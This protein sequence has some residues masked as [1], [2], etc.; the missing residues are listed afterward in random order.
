MKEADAARGSE[1]PLAA[2]RP[3]AGRML[4]NLG[5]FVSGQD[6]TVVNSGVT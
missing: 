1:A 6:T 2:Q 3:W 4:S 5:H